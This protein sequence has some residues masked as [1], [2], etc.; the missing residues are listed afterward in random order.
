MKTHTSILKSCTLSIV[1]VTLSSTIAQATLAVSN[2]GL[3]ESSGSGWAARSDQ[4]VGM[5]FTVGSDYTSWTLD[6]V[7]IRALANGTPTGDF[8]VELHADDGADK[9]AVA[10]LLSFSGSNPSTQAT[11][12]F[13]PSSSYTLSS[14]TKYWLT[15]K[16]SA[17]SPNV[18]G[19]IYTDPTSGAETTALTGWSIGDNVSASFNGGAAWSIFSLNP[20]I[21]AV[22]ATGIIAPESSTLAFLALGGV[23][24]LR[25]RR[26]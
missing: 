17:S 20:A 11:Y 14:G 4:Y 1:A 9:P 2:I 8:I 25:R 5:S 3:P 15:A 18:Y 13:V 21:F 22:N 7:D 10:S 19:W 16:S 23:A 26:V 24:A 12:N 6:S